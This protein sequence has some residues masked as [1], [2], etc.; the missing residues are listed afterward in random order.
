MWLSSGL[1]SSGGCLVEGLVAEHGVEDVA[2]ASGQ[3]DQG[4]VVFFAFGSFA[5]VVGAAGRV[6]QGGEGGQEEGAFEFAVA[7][8]GGV[9]SLDAGA[10]AVGDRGDAGVG[11]QVCG[12]GERGGVADLQEDAGGGPDP[13]AGHGDQD[14]GKRVRIEDLLDLAGE[15]AALGEHG[16]EGLGQPG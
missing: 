12:A 7:G 14:L 10:G 13:D 1:G 16:F 15:V 4:G 9:F 2:A 11:G 5:V 8:A 6:G 3:A